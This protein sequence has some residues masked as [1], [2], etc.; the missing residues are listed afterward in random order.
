[1]REQLSEQQ[2]HV[3]AAIAPIRASRSLSLPDDGTTTM[4]EDIYTTP[5]HSSARRYSRYVPAI[6]TDRRVVKVT[7]HPAPS[8]IQRASLQQSVTTRTHTRTEEPTT[9]QLH[10]RSTPFPFWKRVHWLTLVG[11]GMGVAFLLLVLF[12]WASTTMSQAWEYAHY[13]YP[14]TYQVDADVKHG[15]MSHFLVVNLHGRVIIYEMHPD[16]PA[17][18]KV[19]QGPTL[20]GPGSD[21]Y[22]ATIRFVD[23]NGDKL[24]DMVVTFHDIQAV[25]LNVNGG[26]R[27]ATPADHITGG[28]S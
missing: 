14:R 25:Y 26:F 20:E 11:I 2:G 15:G 22:P 28:N 9:E 18:S 4:M 16:Q 8:P 10:R 3:G 12:S 6:D 24:P 27:P 5:S 21:Q 13:G 23:L 1:M 7:H 17:D 19:Y